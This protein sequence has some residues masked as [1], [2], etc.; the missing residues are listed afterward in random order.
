LCEHGD[1]TV[2]IVSH[3]LEVVK[4]LAQYAI[5]LDRGTLLMDGR[6]DQVIDAYFDEEDIQPEE[7]TAL[8]DV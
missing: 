2:L 1:C 7:A 6:A 8:E 3:G 4:E 5:W